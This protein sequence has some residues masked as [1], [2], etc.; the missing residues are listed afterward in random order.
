M[1]HFSLIPRR[2]FTHLTSRALW[3]HALRCNKKTLPMKQKRRSNSKERP[4]SQSVKRP[5]QLIFSLLRLR[6]LPPI[7]KRTRP[8][9]NLWHR[10]IT[11]QFPSLMSRSQAHSALENS[12]LKRHL[13]PQPTWNLQSTNIC[14]RMPHPTHRRVLTAISSTP[15]CLS[16][17]SAE[18][19]RFAAVSTIFLLFNV[20]R[21]PSGMRCR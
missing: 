4:T 10:P 2:S 21:P 16:L 11:W 3:L 1:L 15:V 5:P 14:R 6:A 18:T 17:S 7:L 9:C 12:L 19:S 20:P 8:P 13:N